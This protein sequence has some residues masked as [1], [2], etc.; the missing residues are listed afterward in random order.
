MGRLRNFFLEKIRFSITRLKPNESLSSA[1]LPLKLEKIRFSITR[2]KPTYQN[3][4][5]S[6]QI[7]WKDKILDYEIETNIAVLILVY[8]VNC[9]LEKI[10][11]SI[12]RLK[13]PRYIVD[14]TGIVTWK[15]KILDYEIE[16]KSRT[17]V[18]WPLFAVRDIR[19]SA[20]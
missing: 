13:P 7:P 20:P 19:S 3:L 11:F 1:E 5:R 18:R 12:T 14:R 8:Y 9:A 10:R 6:L 4:F 15:D 16:T 2:L 17:A